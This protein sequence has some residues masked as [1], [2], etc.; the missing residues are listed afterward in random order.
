[1]GK[2]IFF[3]DNL[4]TCVILLAIICSAASEFMIYPDSH[5]YLLAQT[6]SWGADI[7]ISWSAQIILP[8]L[9]F[10]SAFFGSSSLHIHVSRVF[11]KKKWIR[12]G[13]PWLFGVLILAPEPAFFSYL[14]HD[15]T[16]S[17]TD[18]YLYH[19][20]SD[21]FS[22]GQFWF[23]SLLLGFFLLLIA[24]K[25]C[26]HAFLQRK[27]ASIPGP[28][29]WT[30]IFILHSLGLYIT[31]SVW[32]NHWINLLYVFTFRANF[33]IT[34]LIY[35][36]LGVHAYKYRWLTPHGYTPSAA[37][38]PVFLIISVM[39]AC[40]LSVYAG[41]A[42]PV[43]SA[44]A[45]SLLSLSGLL[46]LTSVFAK[47]GNQNTRFTITLAH[48]SYPLYFVSETLLQTTAYFLQPLALGGCFK[49]I[50]ILTLTFIY[51]YLIS[52]YALIHLPCFKKQYFI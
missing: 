8:V 26:S 52:K 14:N 30:G 45:A 42:L 17:F 3:I 41:P 51:G 27:P 39:Y 1:M 15:S 22:Q 20:W 50:L 44:A 4:R 21:G 13:W 19:F 47:W 23:L 36:F 9:F 18:F 32:S 31:Q 25:K 11:F 35:F 37:W 12:L 16:I 34:S 10:I 43:L 38:L 48:I 24:A 5:A 7:F 29:F 6:R 40:L 33:L 2:R 28:L 46:A 49:I